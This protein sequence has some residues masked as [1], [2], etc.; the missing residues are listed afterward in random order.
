MPKMTFFGIPL[1]KST[2]FLVK[3][4][5]NYT[6]SEKSMHELN[7]KTSKT[8]VEVTTN[9]DTAG[10]TGFLKSRALPICS[11]YRIFT[12]IDALMFF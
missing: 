6:F 3:A 10:V 9:K 5:D 12:I 2:F 7:D 1:V 8:K 4:M 11:L